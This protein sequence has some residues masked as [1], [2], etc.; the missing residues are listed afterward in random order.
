MGINWAIKLV[1]LREGVGV[2][3]GG[4]F[5]EAERLMGSGIEALWRIWRLA[6]MLE[7]LWGKGFRVLFL[8]PIDK[9]MAEMIVLVLSSANAPRKLNTSSFSRPGLENPTNP[10]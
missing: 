1:I 9:S 10:Y 2:E 5:L 7:C 3:N 8:R 6:Q 4:G